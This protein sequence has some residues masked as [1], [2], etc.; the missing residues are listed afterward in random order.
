MDYKDDIYKNLVT[1][2]K[3]FKNRPYHLAKFLIENKALNDKFSKDV[4]N[5]N[6]LQSL[7]KK[8]DSEP[9]P[10]FSSIS[11]MDDFFSSF[12]FINDL[13]N[14]TAEE[15]ESDLN[16]KLDELI[17]NEKFEEAASIRDYMY[18]RGYKRRKI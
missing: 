10:Y 4:L 6:K 1:L 13:K 3:M 15:I 9:V 5:S 18:S 14:K 8:E 16:D 7:V 2:L 12:L 11:E 17:R